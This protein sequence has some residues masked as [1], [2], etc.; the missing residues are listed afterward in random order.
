MAV[1]LHGI[2]VFDDQ[3]APLAVHAGGGYQGHDGVIY[4]M[5]NDGEPETIAP[6]GGVPVAI[7]QPTL[8]VRIAF[9]R[10][11][12]VAQG[13]IPAAPAAMAPVFARNPAKVDRDVID[14][15]SKSGEAL[16]T[17]QATKSLF[18]DSTDKF[19]LDS[20]DLIGFVDDVARRAKSCGWNLFTI[21]DSDGNA[22][23]LLKQHGELTLDEIYAH[24]EPITTAGT[25]VSDAHEF[26]V[27]GGKE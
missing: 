18:G 26:D 12:M 24:I 14:Y 10:T 23:D 17:K 7:A 1:N 3:G 25:F 11:L 21:N 27:Q 19:A 9:L 4:G 8:A 5:D 15:K 13:H 22:K 2:P 6:A 16:Y 20:A